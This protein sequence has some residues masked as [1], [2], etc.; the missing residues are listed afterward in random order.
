M[1]S[2]KLLNQRPN[3]RRK[4]LLWKVRQLCRFWQPIAAFV[5]TVLGFFIKFWQP[6]LQKIAQIVEWASHFFS[7]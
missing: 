6:I 2:R 5:L 7:D 3:R 4:S 1:T